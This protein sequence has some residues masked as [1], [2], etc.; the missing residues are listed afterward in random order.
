MSR[1]LCLFKWS[2]WVCANSGRKYICPIVNIGSWMGV[3]GMEVVHV[4]GGLSW[5]L[6]LRL[7]AVTVPANKDLCVLAMKLNGFW[8]QLAAVTRRILHAL[9]N[10]AQVVWPMHDCIWRITDKCRRIRN[11]RKFDLYCNADQGK[12]FEIL[13]CS[14]YVSRSER[15]TKSQNED[16]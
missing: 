9:L 5:V 10:S 7:R 2:P 13:G 3:V 15:R 8:T 6:I 4:S 12:K 14:D 16:W 1:I 11:S